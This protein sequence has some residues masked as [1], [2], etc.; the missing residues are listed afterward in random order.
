MRRCPSLARGLLNEPRALSPEF[1]KPMALVIL[2]RPA[3]WLAAV[4]TGALC[5]SAAHAQHMT[6]NSAD[7]NAGWGRYA[8]S[9]NHPVNVSTRDANGNAVITIHE[10]RPEVLARQREQIVM[11]Q[12]ARAA[13]KRQKQELEFARAQAEADSAA[14]SAARK[15]AEADAAAASQARKAAEQAREAATR[16][17]EAAQQSR[18]AAARA[19][20]QATQAREAAAA[21]ARASE[22]AKNAAEEA[23]NEAARQLQEAEDYL[24]EVR[25]KPGQ[26]FGQ[27]WWIDRELYEQKKYLPTAKGCIA[28]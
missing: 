19:R 17:R 26:A 24:E 9:E 14:A 15:S 27:L 28:K 21:A 22:Q 4:L 5:V 6:T 7:F 20:E 11:A 8:G 25:K 13:R 3:S 18:Q 12:E 23:L 10:T 16:A 1:A 2:A